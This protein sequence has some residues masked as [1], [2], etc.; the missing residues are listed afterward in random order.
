MTRL[1]D[2]RS[3]GRWE[4]IFHGAA[5]WR[6]QALELLSDLWKTCWPAVEVQI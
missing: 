1:S 2:P 4:R 6:I 3:F 5:D